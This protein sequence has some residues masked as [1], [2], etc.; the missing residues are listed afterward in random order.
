M[1][2][3]Q[4]WRQQ[5]TGS[6]VPGRSWFNTWQQKQASC[7]RR[8]DEHSQPLYGRSLAG[9]RNSARRGG[10]AST[11]SRAPP[12][13]DRRS[14]HAPGPSSSP[15]GPHRSIPGTGHSSARTPISGPVD[16]RWRRTGHHS[17][18]GVPQLPASPFGCWRLV[19]TI[20][21]Q[22]EQVRQQIQSVV[23]KLRRAPMNGSYADQCAALERKLENLQ[24]V[25]SSA[26]PS[27]Q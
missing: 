8:I 1:S 22:I 24:R 25:K 2:S 23:R 14:P 17:G 11:S 5:K 4:R 20:D 16:C 18:N 13:T 6:D 26:T 9:S 3:T 19:R 12:A 15:N 7:P 27:P 10:N 21:E